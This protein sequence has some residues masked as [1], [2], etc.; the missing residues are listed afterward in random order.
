[1][2]QLKM[3]RGWPIGH[4]ESENVIAMFFDPGEFSDIS[5]ILTLQKSSFWQLLH[6]MTLNLV[7]NYFRQCSLWK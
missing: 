6:A 4:V 2:K 7:L 3:W 1:M 5:I